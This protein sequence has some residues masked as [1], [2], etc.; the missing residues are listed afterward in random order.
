MNPRRDIGTA[1][2]CVESRFDNPGRLP[3][4]IPE[5]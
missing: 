4:L 1:Y 2:W 5:R 3:T